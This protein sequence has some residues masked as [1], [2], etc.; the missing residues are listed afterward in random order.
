MASIRSRAARGF[1]LIEILVVVALIAL[2][3]TLVAVSVGR[4]L[5]GAKV[6]A[7]G[8]ELVA[9]LRYTCGQAIIR[10]ESQVMALDLQNRTFTAPGRK[11]VELPPGI[12]IRMLTAREEMLDE[13]TGAVR[14]YPDGS[15]TGGRITLER[16]TQHWVIEVHWLTGAVKLFPP[17]EGA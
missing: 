3:L 6:S 2:L 17:R 14:F 11:P 4:S 13:G 12:E 15:S 16:G 10:R 7:A 5:T 1:S 9:A 8:R